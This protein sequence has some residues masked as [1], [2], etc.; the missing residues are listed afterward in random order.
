MH[1][2]GAALAGVATDVRAGQPELLARCIDT[3]EDWS[4]RKGLLA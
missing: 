4:R 3:V 1:R 2:A